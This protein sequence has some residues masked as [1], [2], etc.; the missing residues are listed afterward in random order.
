MPADETTY[1]ARWIF[2]VASPPL[3]RGTV[4]IRGD[5]IAAVEPHGQR[6]ADVDLGNVGLMPGFVNAHTH[7]DLSGARGHCTPGPDFIAWLRQVI[8]F[9][10]SQTPEQIHQAIAAGIAQCILS[11]TTLVGDISAGGASW[12]L[13][14]NAPI[15]AV[16]YYELIGLTRER[17][18]QS[19]ADSERWLD[20][21]PATP[22]CRPGLSPHAPYSVRRE[23]FE[24]AA[25]RAARDGLPVQIHLAET[26]EEMEL[27]EK[28]TG[29]FVEFL[30]EVGAWDPEGLVSELMSSTRPSVDRS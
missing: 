18:E 27:L 14:A 22:T 13:L 30:R 15:R 24:W 21:H 23:L 28:R 12:D 16:C 17:A 5:R 3:E 8:A 29:P 1:T 6:T 26:A 4:T 10:R 11:G 25:A 9:R 7:L 20:A 2:P 19:W